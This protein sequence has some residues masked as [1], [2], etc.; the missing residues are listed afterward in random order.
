MGSSEPTVNKTQC[1]SGESANEGVFSW[2]PGQLPFELPVNMGFPLG[3][4][5]FGYR[6]FSMEIHYDNP[7]LLD[8]IVDNSGV[9]IYYV[10]E[11]RPIQVGIFDIGDPLVELAY[12]PVGAGVREH[13]FDC[14]GGCSAMAIPDS[15]VTVIRSTFHMHKTGIQASNEQIR[16][17]TVVNKAAVEFF[18]FAQ[19][20]DHL[21][22]ADPFKVFPGDSF[23]V[24]CSYRSPSDGTVIFGPASSNEM[25]IASLLYY[26]RQTLEEYQLPW[27]CGYQYVDPCSANYSSRTLADVGELERTFGQTL[28]QA[29]PEL[30]QAD[31][32]GS[33]NNS[34][35]CPVVASPS[36]G[37]T[38]PTDDGSSAD[39]SSAS[40]AVASF[41]AS[42]LLACLAAALP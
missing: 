34:I 5:N 24:R 39:T 40:S 15:G 2:A 13:T 20:G 32:S 18:D 26:P 33:F 16:N 23:R 19:Q 1:R 42:I 12:E 35:Q 25:C 31:T 14:G 28:L 3:A 4:D 21:V 27:S 37:G 10:K 7:E 11:S 41:C 9:R 30:I 17:G 38:S 6:S 22:Q 36:P 29:N 8:D